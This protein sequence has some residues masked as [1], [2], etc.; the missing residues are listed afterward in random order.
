MHANGFRRLLV[1]RG[2]RLVGLVKMQDLALGVA[3]RDHRRDWIP[4]AIVGLTLV[5]VL[6]VIGLLV[7]QLPEI[8]AVV[9]NGGVSR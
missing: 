2:S 5:L 6:F 3:A 9:K 8:V 4:N 7:A 1:Y